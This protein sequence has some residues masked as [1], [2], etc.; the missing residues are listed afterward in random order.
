V[1]CTPANTL[2]QVLLQ[3][4]AW[5]ES[6]RQAKLDLRRRAMSQ[7][8]GHDDLDREPLFCVETALKVR[9]RLSASWLWQNVES[10]LAPVCDDL[11]LS[12]QVCPQ[13]TCSK[14]LAAEMWP[15]G[16]HLAYSASLPFLLHQLPVRRACGRRR[17][18]G[19]PG[20]RGIPR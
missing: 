14:G 3:E 5:T 19:V 10:F 8:A 17:E 11:F 1:A 7:H 20:R 18:C 9:V 13:C 6:S 16:L 4:A 15:Q 12:A 2:L